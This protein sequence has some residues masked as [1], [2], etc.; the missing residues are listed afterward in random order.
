MVMTYS[1]EQMAQLAKKFDKVGWDAERVTALGQ[2][3]VR[4]YRAIEELL[5]GKTIQEAVK[6]AAS[7]EINKTGAD[8][9]HLRYLSS[10]TLAATSGQV[11]LAQSTEVFTGHLD[12]D[13]KNWGTDKAGLDTP[14]G[15]P[16][17]IY[18]MKAEGNYK[19]LF[20]SISANPHDLCWQQGQI[21]EF[22]RTH[23]DFL[24]QDG[25]ATFFLF[26]VDGELFVASVRVRAGG[27]ECSVIRFGSDRVWNAKY[28]HR[29]MARQQA[30]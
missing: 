5:D 21:V 26:E 6:A 2:A 20:G 30:A 29:L 23:R 7:M 28:R 1:I 11:T 22:C 10:T 19:S 16:A 8:T 17:D 4:V 14:E 3:N 13:F 12:S 9:T 18:E 15:A 24:C 25:Y 27:L